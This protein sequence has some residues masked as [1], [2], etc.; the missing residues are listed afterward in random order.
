MRTLS[1]TEISSIT[2]GTTNVAELFERFRMRGYQPPFMQFPTG[3]RSSV[4]TR[5]FSRSF[6]TAT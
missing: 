3:Q 6:L 2:G 4:V 1:L 5:L